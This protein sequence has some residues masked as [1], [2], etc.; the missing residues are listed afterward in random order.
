MVA[1]IK[2]L[3]P[4]KIRRLCKRN[5]PALIALGP[6]VFGHRLSRKELIWYI[7]GC[8]TYGAFYDNQLI[9]GLL[10][11]IFSS[12]FNE[13]LIQHL[14]VHPYYRRRGVGTRL[15]R[16]MIGKLTACR[17]TKIAIRVRASDMP[18]R[19]FLQRHDFETIESTFWVGI[20]PP[21]WLLTTQHHLGGPRNCTA[22]G[23]EI[24]TRWRGA[25]NPV[26]M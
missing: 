16:K 10:Y 4:V 3:L 11:S 12:S 13:L 24:A 6:D 19:R 22:I 14:I 25:T 9:G 5:I 23:Q 7:E 2:P 17:W 21:Q 1:R 18:A 15:L 8:R 26:S 20:M